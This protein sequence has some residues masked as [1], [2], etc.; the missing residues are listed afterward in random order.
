MQ[1]EKIEIRGFKSFADPTEVHFGQ[2]VTGVV[3]PNGSGK[4]NIVDAFRWVLGEQKSGQ[5]RLDK[6]T[7][8]LFNGSD[9]R[10]KANMARVAISFSNTKNILPLEYQTVTIA[11]E[12]HRS[13]ES[14]Y[15]INGV[16]CRLKDIRNL[17]TDT[18][19]GP[20]S[21]A[22]IALQ[23]VEGIL[24]DTNNERRR[25]FEQAAGV[26][27]YKT[28]KRETFNKLKLTEADLDR[29]KDLLFEIE[30]NLKT[31]EKQARRA[32][33]YKVIKEQYAD[34]S[35]Q[36]AKK[37][38]DVFS[39]QLSSLQSK[40]DEAVAQHQSLSAKRSGA[41]A[42]IAKRKTDILDEE[43]Q[44]SEKQKH[45][46]EFLDGLR[47][48]ENQ[49][50]EKSNA[51]NYTKEK[52]KAAQDQLKKNADEIERFDMELVDLSEELT[53]KAAALHR[54]EEGHQGAKE[55]L[56]KAQAA[57]SSGRGL[58]SEILPQLRQLEE[59]KFS[60][61]KRL[62]VLENLI[63]QHDEQQKRKM[64][65]RNEIDQNLQT[66]STERDRVK[67]D[68]A[69]VTKQ[70]DQLSGKILKIQE[71]K[72]T[73]EQK[74]DKQK[75][76]LTQ[77]TRALD[78]RTNEY[79]LLQ[80]M[81]DSLEGFPESIK[82]LKK[83]SNWNVD[84]P[85]FSD[86]LSCEEKYRP[87]LESYLE[88]YLNHFIVQSDQDAFKAIRLLSDGQRGRA[89]FF[90][91]DRL[92]ALKSVSGPKNA[93]SAIELVDVEPRFRSLLEVL[94]HDTYVFD[95]VILE[96]LQPQAGQTFLSLQGQV[97][98][99]DFNLG[100]GSLGLFS[101]KKIGRKKNLDQLKKQID[102]LESKKEKSFVAIDATRQ[103]LV[104]IDLASLESELA[105]ANKQL[106]ERQKEL[107]GI[108]AQLNA[109]LQ[110]KENLSKEESLEEQRLAEQSEEIKTITAR[111]SELGSALETLQ[112]QLA[113]TDSSL[114][115]QEASL[116]QAR[117]IFN[118]AEIDRIKAKSAVESLEKDC[119][120]RKNRITQLTNS[121]DNLEAQMHQYQKQVAELESSIQS[122]AEGLQ[123]AYAQ[124]EDRSKE[125]TQKEE[126]YYK[127]RGAINDLEED[128]RKIQQ[129]YLSQQSLI[130]QMK[131]KLGQ[132]NFS[133]RAVKD[134][135]QIEFQRAIEE[136][137]SVEMTDE[138]L[139]EL[140]IKRD[141]IQGRIANYGEINPLAVEA[142]DEMNERKERIEKERDDILEAKESL[143]QTI[144][145]IDETATARFHEAFDQINLNFKEVFRSLF[146]E[147]DDCQLV[148]L[149]PENPLESNIEIIAKPKGKRPRTLTQLSGGEKTLTATALLFSLY[150]LKPAPFCIFDEVDAPLDDANIQ[151]FNKIIKKFSKDSQFIIITHNKETMTAMDVIYGVFMDKPGVS[152]VG[153][154]DFNQ[155]DYAQ[156]A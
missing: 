33:R 94:L 40:I 154:V 68:E 131:D 118:K 115:Q 66:L 15:F 95:N 77:V 156:T 82:F 79:E 83:Q 148:L 93:T 103:S 97:V 76:E 139:T 137:E 14:N 143:L 72:S 21:Y 52:L 37:E 62:A 119:G 102:K 16:A 85:L 113:Q 55:E 89:Q 73:L 64:V 141:R 132:V 87:I 70:I 43:S 127:R 54:L 123:E 7:D 133:R 6:M 32:K 78:A 1:L 18:G 58:R 11:R 10:K 48:Q 99:K 92:P 71:K 12:L 81:V 42:E 88:P 120:F 57:Y 23:M 38:W 49:K 17:F 125:L 2:D 90:V 147:N 130:N 56:E 149:D 136:I 106:A 25:M 28:R 46:N 146:N 112:N 19:V 20:N 151:K 36:I 96:D 138:E 67:K 24:S 108:E 134:R 107:S 86:I 144:K 75:D 140:T 145:E 34:F 45:L 3:G 59:E 126:E 110:R 63:G 84:A 47:R 117:E 74:L 153:A 114:S 109:V 111:R 124:K 100:G 150:L 53:E 104:S 41:E 30:G 61:E 122:I 29:V 5:L 35:L 13:S 9:K 105:S 4:S 8:V 69:L 155:V 31:L 60:I 101:G 135:M 65:E 26:S 27:K 22:I 128:L 121:S 152:R 80:S 142:Y 91:M 51:L 50:S 116:N 129:N 98:Y 39:E 44:L